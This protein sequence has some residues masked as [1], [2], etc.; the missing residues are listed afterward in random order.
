[1]GLILASVAI[2]RILSGA[3]ALLPRL[4]WSDG[5]VADCSGA[6]HGAAQPPASVCTKAS[7]HCFASARTRPI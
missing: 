2:D 4:A 3:G 5:P 1:M 6:G 7:A